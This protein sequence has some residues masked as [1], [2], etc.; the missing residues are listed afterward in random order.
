MSSYR[1]VNQLTSSDSSL[2]LDLGGLNILDVDDP[3]V[4]HDLRPMESTAD[5][6]SSD[7][8]SGDSSF[9]STASSM[10]LGAIETSLQTP[11]PVDVSQEPEEPAMLPD[12]AE[13]VAALV[14]LVEPPAEEQNKPLSE[15]A[16]PLKALGT[17][18][19]EDLRRSTLK[20]VPRALARVSN[21]SF[22]GSETSFASDLDSPKARGPVQIPVFSVP[23]PKH[24]PVRGLAPSSHDAFSVPEH[25]S[26]FALPSIDSPVPS[27]KPRQKPIPI[28]VITPEARQRVYEALPPSQ[29]PSRILKSS[30][31]RTSSKS[32][33]RPPTPTKE[34]VE[35]K[36]RAQIIRSELDTIFKAKCAGFGLPRPQNASTSMAS[37]TT[38]AATPRRPVQE[39][40]KG[41]AE[42]TKVSPSKKV[43]KK[44]LTTSGLPRP[45]SAIST[46]KR[47]P[48]SSLSRPT[49][50]TAAKIAPTARPP[51]AAARRT[52]TTVASRTTVPV[53]AVGRSSVMVP[54]RPAETPVRMKH[55]YEQ[56]AS[57]RTRPLAVGVG[58]RPTLGPAARLVRDPTSGGLVYATSGG[59]SFSAEFS[60]AP[61]RSPVAQFA[62]RSPAAHFTP[63][64][65]GFSLGRPTRP[66]VGPTPTPQHNFRLGTASRTGTLMGARRQPSPTKSSTVP[67]LLVQ[68]DSDD[69]SEGSDS[70]SASGSKDAPKETQAA[71][72][73]PKDQSIEA[74]ESAETSDETVPA[75]E[76]A[77]GHTDTEPNGSSSEPN[78]HA[79][80][81]PSEPEPEKHKEK[82]PSPPAQPAPEPSTPVSASGRPRRTP[83]P[84]DRLV[85]AP[86]P[87]KAAVTPSIAPG[88]SEKELKTQTQRNTMRNQ[89][90]FCAIDRQIVRVPGPRPPSPTG[91]IRTLAEK[92]EE[93]Q[94]AERDARARRRNR[95]SGDP[96]SSDDEPPVIEKVTV[97]SAPGDEEGETWKTPAKKRKRITSD[98]EDNTRNVR[99]DRALTVFR[100]GLG[101]APRLRARSTEEGHD[102]LD[103]RRTASEEPARSALKAGAQIQ[104]DRN[105]NA[106][107]RPVEKLKRQKITVTAVFYDGEEPVPEPAKNTRSKKKKN[108]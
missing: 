4:G 19:V 70:G 51:L 74:P 65:P 40:V 29:R 49:A 58:T 27:P 89:V 73:T 104:L 22:V 97:E 24:T 59:Q 69:P 79:M 1:G 33:N 16:T 107:D 39:P 36:E 8:E 14:S 56:P 50:S 42:A 90:Y 32:E 72:D 101:E 25:S 45:T 86:V 28:A 54:V 93:E 94:K 88:L 105:G 106:V 64:S 52:A 68:R 61:P 37:S 100:G 60:V 55:A 95:G 103:T 12:S 47:R 41:L 80:T 84:V 20:P 15:L 35:T 43:V 26:D 5:L 6:G 48:E 96:S 23:S 98:E 62:P 82:T 9:R 53:T 71:N 7:S 83:K 87:T 31:I 108:A 92:E 57:V 30:H 46:A 34:E 85:Q 67:T 75:P 76:S 66:G 78:G 38:I 81:K 99:W 10:S 2:Q 77:P 3:E 18:E 102:S 44:A 63:R 11:A 91:S 17:L 21:A 13:A